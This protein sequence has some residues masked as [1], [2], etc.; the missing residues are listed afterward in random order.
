MIKCPNCG[1]TAQL[2]MRD[3]EH[4]LWRDQITIYITYSCGCGHTFVTKETYERDEEKQKIWL[5]N[6]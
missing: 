2:M 3:S 1:S 4:F 5:T 6:T